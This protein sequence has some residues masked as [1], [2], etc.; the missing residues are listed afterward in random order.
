MDCRRPRSDGARM[1]RMETLRETCQGIPGAENHRDCRRLRIAGELGLQSELQE[2]QGC[3]LPGLSRQSALCVLTTA[4]RAIR[5]CSRFRNAGMARI[6][7]RETVGYGSDRAAVRESR[8]Q[9]R[10]DALH[11][12]GQGPGWRRRRRVCRRPPSRCAAQGITVI[13]GSCP[14]QFLRPDPVHRTL[15]GLW[16]LLGFLR[17]EHANY[18]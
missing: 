16:G 15:R 6:H 17:I 4:G 8:H 5:T 1:F 14:A 9:A 10:L 12:G 13:P 7:S 2:V 11:D 18:N 3:R